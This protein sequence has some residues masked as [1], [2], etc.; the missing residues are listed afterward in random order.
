MAA[1]L[2]LPP[3]APREEWL[4]ARRQG[5]TASEVATVLG[6]S[7]WDSAFNLY[8]RKL[9][10]LDEQPDNDAM[11][12]GRHLEP[13]IADRWAE[14]HPEWHVQQSGL[15]ASTE[16]AWQLATPDRRLTHHTA[17]AT[18]VLEIKTSGTYEGW[19]PDGSDEI[20]PYYRAQV[21]W[22]LDVLGLEV[23]HVTC[24]FLSSRTRRDYLVRY[25]EADVKLMREAAQEFM[26]RIERQDPPPID[27]HPA[28]T[29]ALKTLHPDV[30]D[31][32]AEVPDHLATW[33]A[34]ACRALAEAKERKAAIEHK[35]RAAAGSARR[36]VTAAG[37]PV[38]TRSI[39]ERSSIDVDRLRREHPDAY[40]ACRT[41][42]TVDTLRPA[43]SRKDKA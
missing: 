25:D 26:A 1:R 6:L 4:E 36:L 3:D 35:L 41:T 31:V 20:P 28:T 7:P 32:E 30:E 27:H 17:L 13:W 11:S 12:L 34:D 23:G 15:Y 21:L 37:E 19:G 24:L 40:A 22:Q 33:Y 16:R 9:G 43:R 14:D 38:A 29:A 5:V 8:W 39:C 18:S 10:E 42:T 2:V